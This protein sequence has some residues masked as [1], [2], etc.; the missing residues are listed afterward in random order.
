[1]KKLLAIAIL[2]ACSIRVPAQSKPIDLS[3]GWNYGYSDEGTGFANLN[4]WYG[5]VNWEFSQRVGLSFEHESFWGQF[6]G[7]EANQHAWLGGVSVKLRGGNPKISPFL[8]PMGGVTRSSSSGSVEQQPTFQVGAGADI[9]LKGNL[10]LEVV[11]AEYTFTYG[12]GSALN[13]Y[14]AGA[15]LQY[16]FGKK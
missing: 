5:T 2:A 12:N 10:S 4:G 11:P 14:Q 6:Q 1:M 16:T 15:G 13:T 7:A 9:T 3:L 8:Q